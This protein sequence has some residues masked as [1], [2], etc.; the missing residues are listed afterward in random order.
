MDVN[1]SKKRLPT[2]VPRGWAMDWSILDLWA[3]LISLIE[4]L[5]K[6]ISWMA[7]KKTLSMSMSAKRVA[8]VT[9]VKKE[10]KNNTMEQMIWLN[11][12]QVFLLPYC[13][14]VYFS[15]KGATILQELTDQKFQRERKFNEAEVG[16]SLVGR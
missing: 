14:F 7:R 2:T 5:S 6:E 11:T 8:S 9:S 1:F 10:L 15:I 4:R 3:D 16:Q 12:I 13:I